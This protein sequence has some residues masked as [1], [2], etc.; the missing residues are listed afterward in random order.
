M[1]LLKFEKSSRKVPHYICSFLHNKFLAAVHNAERRDQREARSANA[2]LRT[3][4]QLPAPL[5]IEISGAVPEEP[6]VKIRRNGS[7]ISFGS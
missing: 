2:A 6:V 3:T 5:E 7:A 4:L 1:S